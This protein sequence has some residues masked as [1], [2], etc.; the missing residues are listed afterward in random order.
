MRVIVGVGLGGNVKV[1]IGVVVLV[2]EGEMLGSGV[3]VPVIMTGAS[4]FVGA[5]KVAV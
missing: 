5:G 3:D 4:V 1:G 2:G